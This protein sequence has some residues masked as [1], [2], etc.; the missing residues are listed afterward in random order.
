VTRG[1]DE[2]P[3]DPAHSEC[4][5]PD[6]GE[7]LASPLGAQVACDTGFFAECPSSVVAK[8][9]KLTKVALQALPTQPTMPNPCVGVPRNPWCPKN[10]LT[11]PPY[12]VPGAP[13]K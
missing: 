7:P 5:I 1:V 13:A 6:A 4:G 12:P 9:P 3:S 8:Y 10:S 11:P 2:R